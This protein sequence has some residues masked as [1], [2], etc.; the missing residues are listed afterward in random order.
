LLL[1]HCPEFGIYTSRYKVGNMA[2]WL[3]LI[4]AAPIA[5]CGRAPTPI[6]DPAKMPWID[7]KVQMEGLTNRD[8]RIRGISAFNLG[9][10]GVKSVDALPVLEKLAK[11]DPNP[12]VRDNAQQAVDKI[13]SASDKEQK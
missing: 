8:V 2:W 12:K 7:P 1:Y 10:I 3:F 13:R 6:I 9:N 11:D 5:G 4:L